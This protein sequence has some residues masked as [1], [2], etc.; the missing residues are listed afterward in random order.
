M[1]DKGSGGFGF[2]YS[3]ILKTEHFKLATLI[4][5]ASGGAIQGRVAVLGFRVPLCLS[6]PD[7]FKFFILHPTH[8]HTL[9]STP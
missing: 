6:H 8:E 5:F 2:L 9:H 4:N 1:E 7:A 3:R